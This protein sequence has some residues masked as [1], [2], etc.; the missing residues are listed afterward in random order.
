MCVWG[1]GGGG[2]DICAGGVRG[3]RADM[4]RGRWVGGY[5]CDILVSGDDVSYV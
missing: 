2:T 4:Y 5:T 1:W 3:A